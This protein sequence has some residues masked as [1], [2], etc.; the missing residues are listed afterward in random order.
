[1]ARQ[2]Q[3]QY[4][5]EANGTSGGISSLED[6]S[7]TVA[8]RLQVCA[9]AAWCFETLAILCLCMPSCYNASCM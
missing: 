7:L 3:Q 6:D 4:D 8:R 1:M 9:A 2:L 5:R